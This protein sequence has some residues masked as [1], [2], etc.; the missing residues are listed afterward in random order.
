MQPTNQGVNVTILGKQFM[1]AC[2]EEQQ[3]SLAAAAR[4]L[5]KQMRE[6][7]KS[8][9]V[10]GAERCAI[11]AA[12]NIANDLLQAQKSGGLDNNAAE[13]LRSLHSKIDAAL[14]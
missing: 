9:K 2:P 11:M 1:V 14:G 6:I 3:E 5:D 4:Y 8:G 10:I 13:R 12:L 7:Q